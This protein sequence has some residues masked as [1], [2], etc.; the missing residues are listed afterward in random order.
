MKELQAA[1]LGKFSALSGNPA[2]H[3]SLYLSLG[4]K[5]FYSKAKQNSTL[6]YGVFYFQPIVHDYLFIE[7]FDY[8]IVQFSLFDENESVSNIGDMENY[9]KTLFDWCTLTVSNYTFLKMERVL[10]RP[11]EWLPEDSVW[12]SVIQ[13][14]VSLES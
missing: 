7:E 9:L 6:P 4:G 11:A 2:V 8:V 3:N 12:Q 10:I 14:R 5:L 1:I 13:Y